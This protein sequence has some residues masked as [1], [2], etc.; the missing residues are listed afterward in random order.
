MSINSAWILWIIYTERFTIEVYSIQSYPWFEV[1]YVIKIPQD[2]ILLEIIL[3]L[4]KKFKVLVH[5][6]IYFGLYSFREMHS[7]FGNMKI[8]I[9]I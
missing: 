7:F 3:F 9:E 2:Q 5:D 8:W 4:W 6:K 1:C